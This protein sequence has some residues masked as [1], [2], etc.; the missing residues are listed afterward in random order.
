MILLAML[1]RWI[2][3]VELLP[4]VREAK[5]ELVVAAILLLLLNRVL[6]AVRWRLV[7]QPYT[8]QTS[9]ISLLRISLV[10]GFLSTFLPSQLSADSLRVYLLNQE[11]PRTPQ[12]ISSVF[13]D[14]AA[15]F[16]L[17]K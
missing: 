15:G 10:T 7:L 12:V 11:Y 4:V 6:L 17:R 9:T 14:R 1:V 5:L 3:P 2:D 16:C 8:T 13:V